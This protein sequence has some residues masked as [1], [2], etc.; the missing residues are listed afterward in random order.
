MNPIDQQKVMDA[1]A[2]V[3]L[4]SDVLID[5]A[6]SQDI[7]IEGSVNCGAINVKLNDLLDDLLKLL[8][9][10]KN[11]GQRQALEYIKNST[12]YS[13]EV[14]YFSSMIRD[15]DNG[16]EIDFPDVEVERTFYEL[17]RAESIRGKATIRVKN[18]HKTYIPKSDDSIIYPS[19]LSRKYFRYFRDITKYKI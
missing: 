14:T 16:K 10:P 8:P 2:F 9:V 7:D 5:I 3:V 19:N 17:I 1:I 15:L 6:G 13:D 11:F 12:T 18:S 4:A